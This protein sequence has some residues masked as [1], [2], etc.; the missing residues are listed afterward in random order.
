MTAR[1]HPRLKPYLVRYPDHHELVWPI[2]AEAGAA[3]CLRCRLDDA[4]VL[5]L[6]GDFGAA[7]AGV[8]RRVGMDLRR[9][10]AARPSPSEK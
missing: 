8:I 1:P 4:D 10:A 6:A 2:L 9:R 5:V 3:D 7:A